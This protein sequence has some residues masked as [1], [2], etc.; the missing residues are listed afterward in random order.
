MSVYED[1]PTPFTVKKPGPLMIETEICNENKY[2]RTPQSRNHL[3]VQ[4]SVG[5]RLRNSPKSR[6]SYPA[7]PTNML[8]ARIETLPPPP[9]ENALEERGSHYSIGQISSS[10]QSRS[11]WNTESKSLSAS[12]EIKYEVALHLGE[13]DTEVYLYEISVRCMGNKFKEY[14]ERNRASDN[15]THVYLPSYVGV[16]WKEA[17]KMAFTLYLICAV[18]DACN[19]DSDTL[20]EQDIFF[21]LL[22]AYR[23][24]DIH[25]IELLVDICPFLVRKFPLLALLEREEELWRRVE[26]GISSRRISSSSTRGFCVLL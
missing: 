15:I 5:N 14:L 11:I 21:L 7:T 17:Y 19:V 26:Q 23:F 1:Y 12:R 2:T 6:T 18:Q 4:Y 8:N 25:P 20:T 13:N 16:H 22:I 24:K 10:K 3:S 9:D